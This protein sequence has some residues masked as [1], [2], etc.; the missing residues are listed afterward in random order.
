MPRHQKSPPRQQ[1]TTARWGKADEKK[2]KEYVT[3]GKIDISDTTPAKNENI[4]LAYFKERSKQ[5]FCVHYRA[6]AATLVCKA[7]RS[8]GRRGLHEPCLH[9]FLSLFGTRNTNLINLLIHR[10]NLEEP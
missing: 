3:L 8:G 6:L 9:S 10:V 4:R 7:K 1:E 2:F 5:T